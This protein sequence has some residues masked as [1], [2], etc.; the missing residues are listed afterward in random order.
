[1]GALEVEG[2]RRAALR[3]VSLPI[4]LAVAPARFDVP[5]KVLRKIGDFW[6]CG[7]CDKMYWEGEK[8][9]DT[10]QTFWMLFDSKEREARMKVADAFAQIDDCAREKR[11]VCVAGGR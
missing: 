10:R 7:R 6:R 1:L 5:A 4:W 2:V 9:S 3:L 8:V 11:F